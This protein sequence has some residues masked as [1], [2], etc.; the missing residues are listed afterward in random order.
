MEFYLNK[1]QYLVIVCNSNHHLNR[2]QSVCYSDPHLN[3]GQKDRSSVKQPIKFAQYYVLSAIHY[4]FLN[5]EPFN[6]RTHFFHLNTGLVCYSNPHCIKVQIQ[7]CSIADFMNLTCP[8]VLL[9]NA[10]FDLGLLQPNRQIQFH[11]QS[12]FEP[13]PRSARSSSADQSVQ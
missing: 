10:S 11:R 2:R 9:D 13:P 3:S 6:D 8:E 1:I 12:S 7:H 4:R 5:N